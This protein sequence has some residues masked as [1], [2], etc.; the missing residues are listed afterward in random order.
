M[1]PDSVGGHLEYPQTLNR[2]VY[3]GNNPLTLTDP[4]GMDTVGQCVG[5]RGCQGYIPDSRSL[6]DR[7]QADLHNLL[8]GNAT[9]FQESSEENRYE[10]GLGARQQ[11]SS[12]GRG[13][14]NHVSNLL[15]GHSWNYGMRE[16]V[17]ETIVYPESEPSNTALTADA[18]GVGGIGRSWLFGATSAALS[19]ADDH[20]APNLYITGLTFAPEGI[21]AAVIAGTAVK[22]FGPAR[23][24]SVYGSCHKS[25]VQRRTNTDYKRWVWSHDTKSWLER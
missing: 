13:F 6:A 23:W 7:F 8:V 1:S 25:H 16:S 9:A 21:G 19:V 18:I 15:D 2:Y 3:V 22:D 20:S 10:E 11:G 14:W 24:K 17:T 4:T 12:D 5:G